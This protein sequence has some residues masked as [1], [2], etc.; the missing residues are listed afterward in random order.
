[1]VEN[2]EEMSPLLRL[3]KKKGFKKIKEKKGETNS[4]NVRARGCGT[5]IPNNIV[6]NAAKK[7]CT[8]RMAFKL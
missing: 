8:A 7:Y 5:G 3:G 6:N 2:A 1:M 4:E